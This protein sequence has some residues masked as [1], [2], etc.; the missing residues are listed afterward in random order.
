[1]QQAREREI[2]MM[3][4]AKQERDEFDRI[5]QAQKEAAEAERRQEEAKSE[6]RRQHA[7]QLKAQILLNEE[8]ELQDRR[9]YLE[10]GRRL[11]NEIDEERYRLE[12]IKL[13][14]LNALKE[15]GVPD[16]YRAEL[17]KKK[18]SV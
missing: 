13:S 17:A 18:I 1:M 14:K 9:E 7:E 11:R 10:E 2:R 5:I 15:E 3:I 6:I 16:K 4:Q 8:K 12:H